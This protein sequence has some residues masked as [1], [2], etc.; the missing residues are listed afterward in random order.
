MADSDEPLDDF[1]WSLVDHLADGGKC[2]TCAFLEQGHAKL[3]EKISERYHCPVCRPLGP[4]DDDARWD[5]D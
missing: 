3:A 5:L 2:P 1:C 4:L